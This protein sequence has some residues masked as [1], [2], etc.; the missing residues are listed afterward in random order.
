MIKNSEI[1]KDQK[2][3]VFNDGYLYYLTVKSL[4]R[5]KTDGKVIWLGFGEDGKTSYDGYYK[6]EHLFKTKKEAEDLWKLRIMQRVL[7][8]K[9]VKH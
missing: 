6:I 2:I 3:Y 5:S 4:R 9:H 1:R 7:R 8:K